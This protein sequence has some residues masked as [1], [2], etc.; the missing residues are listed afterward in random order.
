MQLFNLEINMNKGP[1]HKKA[2]AYIQNG[3]LQH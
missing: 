1:T 3:S 2:L